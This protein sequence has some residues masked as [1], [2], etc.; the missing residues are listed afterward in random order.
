MSGKERLVG[1][2]TWYAS[3]NFG[4]NLQAYAL[5]NAI[6]ELGYRCNLIAPLHSYSPVAV[7]KVKNLMR[8]V[9]RLFRPIDTLNSQTELF[10]RDCLPIANVRTKTEFETMMRQTHAF[11]T[12]SDQVWNPYYLNT[13]YMLDFVSDKRK[14]AYGASV[15]VER[16]PESK[17]GPYKKWLPEYD[18]IGLR[19]QAG[20]D[21]LKAIVPNLNMQKVLDPTFLLDGQA[22]SAFAA[23]STEPLRI[24]KPYILCYLVGHRRDNVDC[25]RSLWEDSAGKQLAIIPSAENPSLAIKGAQVMQDVGPREF[26]QLII[27]ADYICT[28]SFHAT[29]LS[30]N[31]SKPFIE[32]VRFDEDDAASQ[33]SR[34]FELLAAYGLENRLASRAC[35]IRF[36]REDLFK[37][38]EKLKG[39]RAESLSFLTSSIEGR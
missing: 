18:A 28:D 17:T 39:D 9:Y 11:V 8:P 35:Q 5:T 27:G 20:I 3:R 6:C 30:I 15:G 23:S 31:L 10:I 13:F 34:V 16:I 2:V 24:R 36:E 12:G 7:Q 25:V 32:F 38:Q 21:A 4:T 37:A 14:V 19:E 1:V 22:W 29:A 33:N 26:V